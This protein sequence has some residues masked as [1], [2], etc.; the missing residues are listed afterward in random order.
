MAQSGAR[1]PAR[2]EKRPWLVVKPMSLSLTLCGDWVMEVKA[3]AAAG[4]LSHKQGW[5]K[6]GGRWERSN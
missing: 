1:H 4:R 2:T 3:G 5:E 6:G